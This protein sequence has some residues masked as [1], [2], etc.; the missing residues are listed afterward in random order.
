MLH[1]SESE[2]RRLLPMQEAIRLVREGF[3]RLAR[4]EA[5]NQPRRRLHLPSSSVLHYMAA[6]CG[7]YFGIKIY[8]THPRQGAHFLFL[9]Y[10]A[11][12]GHPLAVLEA[13]YL[14]QIRTGAAS[15]YLTDLL[16]KPDAASLGI[17]GS[18]FQ[19]RSQLEA[20]LA[21]RPVRVVRVWSLTAEKRERFARECSELLQVR[22]QTT[23]SARQAVEGAEILVT[24]TNSREPVIEDG[25]VRG[26]V[27][28]NAMGSNQATRREL[29]AELVERAALIAVDSLEQ[30]RMESGD[31]LLAR[32]EAE[33]STLPIVE[34]KDLTGRKA[35]PPREGVTIFK[36]HGLAVE[37]V[38]AAAFVYERALG[39]GLG[40]E[41]PVL[42]GYS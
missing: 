37:D 25:W 24:A 6:W 5:V 11:E 28:I 40:R 18:G 38:A 41:L 30:A 29:P 22:V 32:S 26:T 10:R 21:V 1:L 8:S 36:S 17:I 33:W 7:N 27:H 35:H 39:E 16:A 31:L 2:V 15:G 23:H 9:L 3:E 42:A 19:A 12:D 34:V 20:I 14:G 4:G 13:N